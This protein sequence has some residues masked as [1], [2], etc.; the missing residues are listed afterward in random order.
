MKQTARLV[1]SLQNF[2]CPIINLIS[3]YAPQVGLDQQTKDQIWEDLDELVQGLS[4]SDKLYIGGDFNGCVGV[5]CVGYE[6]VHEGCV[7]GVSNN[8]GIAILE[9]AVAYDFVIA[10]TCFK[11]REEHLITFEVD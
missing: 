2:I 7:F 6:G 9:F 10:N 1:T 3:V 4:E 8:G 5:N 11:K